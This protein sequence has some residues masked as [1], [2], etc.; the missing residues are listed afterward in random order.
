MVVQRYGQPRQDAVAINTRAGNSVYSL[1]DDEAFEFHRCAGAGPRRELE[2]AMAEEILGI[3]VA[4]TR[5]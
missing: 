1:S 3:F 5:T 4:V 2:P